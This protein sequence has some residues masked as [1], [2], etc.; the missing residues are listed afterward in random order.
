MN[1]ITGILEREQELEH[2]TAALDAAADGRGRTVVIEGPAGIGKTRL[3][4]DARAMAKT[5]GFGRI[6]ATGDELESAMAWSVVRQLVELSLSR[7]GPEVRA[8]LLAGPSGAALAALGEAPSEASAGDA[9]LART[10]HALWWVAVDLASLRPLLITVDDAQWADLASLRFLAYLSRRISDLPIALVVSMR[11]AYER[12]GPLA[13]LSSGRGGQRILPRPLSPEAVAAL[14]VRQGVRPAAEVAGAI[15]AASG[16]NPFLA[17]MLVDELEARG[18]PLDDAGTVAVVA[19]LGPSAIFRA[20]LGRLPEEA[21]ALASGAAVLGTHSEPS[22]AGAVAGLDDAGLAAA[23]DA[24]VVGHVL[25]AGEQELDFVHP[26]VREAVLGQLRPGERSSLHAAAARTLHARGAPTNR[27]AAHLAQSPSG[28]LSG[29]SKILRE[30]A[31]GL[32]ADG[33]A[34]TAAIT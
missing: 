15:Y 13:E 33:D 3:V 29:A 24:L 32:L 16:G 28:T 9:A 25:R 17:G 6:Q 4:Q 27:V 8:Q 7:Y 14:S 26:V 23:F 1:P 34:S 2:I 18:V 10:L 31:A 5:R 11:P 22:V 30:A 19:T 20:L 12:S 21:I